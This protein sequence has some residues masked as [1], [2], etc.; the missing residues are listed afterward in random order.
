[1][2]RYELHRILADHRAMPAALAPAHRNW[3]RNDWFLR[4][5]KE[6]PR[7]RYAALP[8]ADP[9][10]RLHA[11][12]VALFNDTAPATAWPHSSPHIHSTST[13]RRV[14]SAKWAA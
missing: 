8:N 12:E 5:T 3:L 1:M 7:V 4:T 14:L 9:P 10:R 2:L 6:I 11:A 13:C